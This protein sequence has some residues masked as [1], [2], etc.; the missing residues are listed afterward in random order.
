MDSPFVG[1]HMNTE[2]KTTTE[3]ARQVSAQVK[4]LVD[5][6][7]KFF[8]EHFGKLTKELADLEK[9]HQETKEEIRRGPRRTDGRIV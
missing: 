6:A 5:G 2:N 4:S 7:F 1:D 3:E 9:L 8:G